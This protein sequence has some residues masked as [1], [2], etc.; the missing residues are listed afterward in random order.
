MFNKGMGNL[1]KQAQQMQKNINK[2]QDELKDLEVEGS[3]GGNAVKVIVNGKKDVKS[4]KIDPDILSEDV[5]MVE[6]MILGAIK[7]A[8]DNADEV[9]EKKMKSI[10]G[11]MM[12]NIPG[13]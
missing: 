11:G 1:Y 2:A 5:D 7:N 9:S 13:L 8:M 3:S 10:T 6:D 12:P 4:I